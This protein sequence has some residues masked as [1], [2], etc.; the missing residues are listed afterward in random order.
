[1]LAPQ[2]PKKS[3]PKA[4]T[5]YQAKPSSCPKAPY[6]SADYFLIPNSLRIWKKHIKWAEVPHPIE[7]A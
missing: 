4:R 5:E 6:F 1:V 3:F 7:W 2:M